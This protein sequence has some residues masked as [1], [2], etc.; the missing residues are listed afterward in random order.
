LGRILD[1]EAACEQDGEEADEQNLEDLKRRYPWW[2]SGREGKE[3]TAS[4]E[5]ADTGDTVTLFEGRNT[6]V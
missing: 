6:R 4:P 3:S 1:K 2:L 5:K